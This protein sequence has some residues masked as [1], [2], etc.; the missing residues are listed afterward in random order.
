MAQTRHRTI[1]IDSRSDLDE[2][3][4]HD[5]IKMHRAVKK[6]GNLSIDQDEM[7]EMFDDELYAE[8]NYL[9]KKNS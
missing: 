4:Q 9:L 1:R 3:E 7:R 8:L 5:T 6:K 2:V